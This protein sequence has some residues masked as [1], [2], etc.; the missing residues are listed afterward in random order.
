MRTQDLTNE[1]KFYKLS[2]RDTFSL[3][4]WVGETFD[5]AV[6]F[7]NKFPWGRLETLREKVLGVL[8]QMLLRRANDKS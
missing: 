1:G 6:H 5:V 4:M 7:L 3:Y 2:L 8:F